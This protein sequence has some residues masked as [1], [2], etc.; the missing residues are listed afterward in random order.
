[1]KLRGNNPVYWFL[2]WEDHHSL[3]IC[4]LIIAVFVSLFL[5]T[6]LFD[7]WITQRNS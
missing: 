7:E 3:L 2:T 4:F 6:A 1:V 5:F